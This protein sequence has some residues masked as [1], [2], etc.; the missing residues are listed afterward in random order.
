MMVLRF[1]QWLFFLL[2]FFFLGLGIWL[3]LAGEDITKA[4]GALW[5]MLDV[6]SL[7]LTQVIIQRHLHLPAFW[8]NAIVPYLLQRPAWESILWLF[9]GLMLVGGLLSVIGRRPKRRHTF[10]SE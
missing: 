1:F 5:Y 7:N 6:S 9:I 10:R 2:A 8:D 4:A 3:W